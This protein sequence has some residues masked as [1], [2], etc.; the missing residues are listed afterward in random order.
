LR[1]EDPWR[2]LRHANGLADKVVAMFQQIVQMHGLGYGVETNRK[3]FR[4]E[5]LYQDLPCRSPSVQLKY[6]DCILGLREARAFV[7]GPEVPVMI[8]AHPDTT[9][10]KDAARLRS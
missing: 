10:A 6:R 8:A 4:T 7:V 1:L 3:L 9:T 5:C 2:A